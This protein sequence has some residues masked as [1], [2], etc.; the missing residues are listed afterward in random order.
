MSNTPD[1]DQGKN[2]HKKKEDELS[3][4]KKKSQYFAQQFKE[5]QI[6]LSTAV[7]AKERLAAENQGLKTTFE[8]LRKQVGD[9]DEEVRRVTRINNKKE[10]E[11]RV[12][13]NRFRVKEDELK[14]ALSTIQS[15]RNEATRLTTETTRLGSLINQN[16]LVPKT[17]VRVPIVYD[18][19]SYNYWT[20][21]IELNKLGSSCN[22]PII[23]EECAV[24]SL[25]DKVR[26][27]GFA[28]YIV[29]LSTERFG[30]EHYNVERLQKA[31]DTA[32]RLSIVTFRYGSNASVIK[33]VIDSDIKY[34]FIYYN[35]ALIKA[36]SNDRS[37]KKLFDDV[38]RLSQAHFV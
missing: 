30:P 3:Q 15:L 14:N 32:R 7:L 5:S 1:Q 37:L 19:D 12:A 2:K 21:I 22:P 16:N 18:Q 25:S 13:T 6:N 24:G 36:D 27:L 33:E 8:S 34:Q 38:A 28:L 29:S 10:E 35:G 17:L 9:K 31:K 4:E 23:F 11:L 20:V 26:D